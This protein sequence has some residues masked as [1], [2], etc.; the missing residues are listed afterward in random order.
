M[1]REKREKGPHG[2]LSDGARF[3]GRF[4]P[5]ERVVNT[6]AAPGTT[7]TFAR[8]IDV[9][10]GNGVLSGPNK[11]LFSGVD[12]SLEVSRGRPGSG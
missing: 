9:F 3:V 2:H 12:L 8:V 6:L 10:A 7:A 5:E 11:L 4:L 1:K